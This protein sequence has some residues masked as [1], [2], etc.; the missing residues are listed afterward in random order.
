MPSQDQLQTVANNLANAVQTYSSTLQANFL[1]LR[2]GQE[3]KEDIDAANLHANEQLLAMVPGRR[4]RFNDAFVVEA[5]LALYSIAMLCTGEE[6]GTVHAMDHISDAFKT[7]M[8]RLSLLVAP[9][10]AES[11][12]R[13]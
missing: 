1:L 7:S 11:V 6:Q 3:T 10:V 8:T 4:G 5:S 13:L 2:N 12:S 9:T